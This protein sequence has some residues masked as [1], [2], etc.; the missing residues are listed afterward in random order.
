M[1]ADLEDKECQLGVRSVFTPATG[2]S[3]AMAIAQAVAN[4][5]LV[6]SERALDM[7]TASV[8]RGIKYAG[9]LALEGQLAHDRRVHL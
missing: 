6:A 8:E 3:L 1:P 7:V 5:N 2:K 4:S 9:L